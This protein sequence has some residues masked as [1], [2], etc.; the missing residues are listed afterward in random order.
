MGRKNQMG[1]EN[2]Q[3]ASRFFNAFVLGDVDTATQLLDN[4]VELV[5]RAG[6]VHGIH[7]LRE[8]IGPPD[9]YEI[10]LGRRKMQEIDGVIELSG[11]Y[12][13][14]LPSDD[15]GPSVSGE[16]YLRVTF[17]GDKIVRVEVM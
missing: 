15:Y 5:D 4:T 11:S 8:F 17:R 13:G 6:V 9:D 1:R 16:A 2:K 3:V 12:E 10:E 14:T 7:E